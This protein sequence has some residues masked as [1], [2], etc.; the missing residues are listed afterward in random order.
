MI[1]I[2][3]FISELKTIK[4]QLQKGKLLTHKATYDVLKTVQNGIDK[5]EKKVE[6]FE[7]DE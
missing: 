7:K 5:Y 6:E 2:L 4:E 1:D 3:T